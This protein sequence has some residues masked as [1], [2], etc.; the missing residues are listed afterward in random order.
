LFH[1]FSF[2]L[3]LT[4]SPSIK[5]IATGENHI[6]RIINS[7]SSKATIIATSPDR[8]MTAPQ[9]KRTRFFS[10]LLKLSIQEPNISPHCWG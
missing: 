4:D 2:L 7:V 8:Q 1:Q 3:F 5:P 10:V 9:P 6:S